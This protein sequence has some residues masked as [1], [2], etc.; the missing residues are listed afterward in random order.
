MS[1]R[2]HETALIPGC[3]L[4]IA[5]FTAADQIVALRLM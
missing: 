5:W 2:S 1:A 4:A 3:K